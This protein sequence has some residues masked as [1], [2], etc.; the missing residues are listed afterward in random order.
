MIK[1]KSKHL[2]L[3]KSSHLPVILIISGTAFISGC[4]QHTKSS[5][6][7]IAS[8]QVTAMVLDDN[9]DNQAS[10]NNGAW[11]AVYMSKEELTRP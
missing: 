10:R 4:S 1:V 3:Y 8:L 5:A 6:P 7:T 9:F 2:N 11:G